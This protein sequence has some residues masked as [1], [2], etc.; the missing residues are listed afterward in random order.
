MLHFTKVCLI[1]FVTVVSILTSSGSWDVSDGHM[2]IRKEFFKSKSSRLVSFDASNGDLKIDLEFNM[3]FLEIPVQKSL[4]FAKNAVAKINVPS[5][6]LTGLL[7]LISAVVIP[8]A[9]ML[10]SKKLHFADPFT[11]HYN[12]TYRNLTLLILIFKLILLA[13]MESISKWSATSWNICPKRQISLAY[14]SL[15]GVVNVHC[16]PLVSQCSVERI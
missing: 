11:N 1:V 12:S 9:L 14:R 4:N 13:S 5:L 16:T 8:S 10:I 6:V 15:R 2:N 7:V 3:P